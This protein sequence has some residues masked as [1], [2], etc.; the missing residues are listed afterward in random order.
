MSYYLYS[1]NTKILTLEENK[2]G[3]ICGIQ[4]INDKDK[5][6]F[7]L[8]EQCTIEN[9][10][11]W[12]NKRGISQSREGI[13]D[14]NALL[15]RYGK[16]IPRS[17]HFASLSDQYW[18]KHD[19]SKDTWDKINFFTNKYSKQF[20]D[21]AFSPWLY[22][23][24]VVS[25]FSPDLTTN[26]MLR[27]RWVQNNDKS[28]RLVKAGSKTMHQEPLSE[29]LASMTMEKLN[30]IPFV[31]YDLCIE[32]VTL[33]STCNNFIDQNTE[34]IPSYHLYNNVRKRT[35]ENAYNHL[36][37][38]AEQYEINGMRE[39]L[40]AMIFIDN[41]TGNEDRNL[42]NIGFIRDVNTGKIIGPAPLFDNGTAYWNTKALKED[43]HGTLFA[44]VE[45]EI[46][47]NYK[48]K[49]DLSKLIKDSSYKDIIMRYPN[50]SD[51][52]KENL[53]REIKNKYRS[54]S[55]VNTLTR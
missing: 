16:K 14:V 47:K 55:K 34:L 41:I 18:I 38:V 32:G 1:K 24:K 3:D 13:D 42:G 50:I 52:K 30:I 17:K 46:V 6:P 36:L 51:E 7:C 10:V 15:S 35:G 27:K 8:Q 43:K 25:G 40:D 53:I 37:R 12:M 31:R 9:F 20:G 49:C 28:S 39:Y 21:I 22:K 45:E 33:C 19:D 48:K 4:Q 11:G 54:L 44:D 23:G 5:L 2:D 29:V 26:G